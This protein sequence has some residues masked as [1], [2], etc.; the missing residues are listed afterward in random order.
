MYFIFFCA[1]VKE[2]IFVKDTFAPFQPSGYVEQQLIR[3]DWLQDNHLA[4]EYSSATTQV[5]TGSVQYRIWLCSIFWIWAMK[6]KS[7]GKVDSTLK[8]ICHTLILLS[9]PG[10]GK[11]YSYPEV[12]EASLLATHALWLMKFS[13]IWKIRDF[14]LSL[15]KDIILSISC[16]SRW[17]WCRSPANRFKK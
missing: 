5:N 17:I 16:G 3:I 1:M 9:F 8:I 4:I 10:N 6:T 12:P 11:L 13:N 2:E 14:F 15:C 7:Q